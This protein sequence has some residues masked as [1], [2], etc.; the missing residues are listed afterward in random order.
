MDD[1]WGGLQSLCN[2]SPLK[3]DA[4]RVWDGEQLLREQKL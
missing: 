1:V 2:G 4:A 3:G